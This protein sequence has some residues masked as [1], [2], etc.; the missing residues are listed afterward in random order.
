MIKP[1]NRTLLGTLT[2]A[3]MLLLVPLSL[4]AQS[5]ESADLVLTNAR[6]Y[7]AS[8][9][10]ESA[11][12]LAVVNDRIVFVGTQKDAQKWIGPK[13]VVRH[14]DGRRILP[15]LVDAH[16]HA[17]DI[18]DLDFC[19]LK[20]ESH[21]LRELSAIARA[22]L[23]RY[24]TAPGSRLVIHQWA[25]TTGN[26]PDADYPTLRVALDKAST[27]HQI[28]LLGNDGHHG[29]FN[30]LAL[31]SAKGFDGKVIGLSKATLNKEF[32][33]YKKIIGV[34]DRGEPNGAVN[35]DARF[36]IDVH[37]ML[38]SDL[39]DVAKAPERVAQRLNSV[40]I[41][42]IMDAMATPDSLPV[43]D[44]LQARGQFTMRAVLAQFLDPERFKRANGR[45]DFDAMVEA[46]TAVRARYAKNELIRADFVKLFADGVLEGNPVAVPPTLPNAAS[47]RPYLQ[48]NFGVDKYGVPTVTGYVDTSSP[49]CAQERIDATK[50]EDAAL[51][52]A[53]K[54]EHGFF[55]SQCTISD[56]QL[57]HDREVILEFA[58][59]FHTAG[60]NLHIHAIGDRAVRTAVE[61]IEAARAAN[62]VSTTR[63][64]LAHVQLA[65]PDDVAR[66]GRDHLFVAFTYAWAYTDTGYDMTVIP[67]IDQVSGNAYSSLHRTGGYYDSNAYPVKSVKGAGAI[68]TAG[69]D[70][71][72]DTRDPRP[73]INMS[74]ALT[75]H[76]GS[77]PALNPKQAITIREV[78]DAY[79]INGA[80]MLGLDKDAG[81]IEVGK[82]ADF[83]V[84]DRDIVKLAASKPDDIAN[85]KVLET[86]FKGRQVYRS[87]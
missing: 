37:A 52:A 57:Q 48:P 5:H 32:A 10:A 63:D 78:I 27:E 34:D 56:G 40:G 1:L 33:V 61:A 42:A 82:S 22:C 62:G 50:Y 55:P 77:A 25:Y 14:L 17:M 11:H 18:V 24:Q 81:S 46:A 83:I 51:A 47:L 67:F 85:T 26:Q 54:T 9:V 45:V 13:T 30:S 4:S 86:W 79:T 72:V 7:T 16:I 64:S 35:E 84:L 41:T 15:G 38:N 87:K 43:Y 75:R 73:F 21:T 65:H 36:L 71:P 19:D 68:L 6:I 29:A 80:R 44:A 20:S 49:V 39:A 8:G 28:E 53:F 2:A 12:A 58:R 74:H 31:A 76:G 3:L 70:A 60:F 59:R 66:I 23:E 69:S